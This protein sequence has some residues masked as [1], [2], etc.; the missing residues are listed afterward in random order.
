VKQAAREVPR[1]TD[2]TARAAGRLR[3]RATAD[4]KQEL[5]DGPIRTDSL[6][7]YDGQ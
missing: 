7:D 2:A 4:L 1:G 3:V 6:A 5:A